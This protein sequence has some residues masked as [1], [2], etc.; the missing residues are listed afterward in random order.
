MTNEH[1]NDEQLQPLSADESSS[2]TGGTDPI[3]Y[4]IEHAIEEIVN[5]QPPRWLD[6]IR[7]G[8]LL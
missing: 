8:P 1:P 4:S 3:D 7:T 6:P 5:P 2:T